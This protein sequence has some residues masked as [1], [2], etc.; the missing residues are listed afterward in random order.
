[1]IKGM[2]LV[3]NPLENPPNQT[4]KTRYLHYMFKGLKIIAG[5]VYM[6]PLIYASILYCLQSLVFSAFR[7][8]DLPEINRPPSA[9][10]P[11]AVRLLCLLC[12]L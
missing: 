1:M 4:E 12:P 7:H 8:S 11:A 3:E 5:S 6:A 9:L 2:E 10:Q